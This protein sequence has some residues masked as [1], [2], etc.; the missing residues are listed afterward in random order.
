MTERIVAAALKMG[1]MTISVLPPGRHHTI[2]WE[3]AKHFPDIRCPPPNDQGFLTDNGRFIGREEAVEV[4]KA[5][6][7][8][9]RPKYQ[10]NQLFSE[11]LW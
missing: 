6:G 3:L 7:Q 4:A 10:P 8:I 2:F 9:E 1:E 5:S 11:D